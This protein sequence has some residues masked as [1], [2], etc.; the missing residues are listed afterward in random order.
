MTKMM[1]DDGWRLEGICGEYVEKGSLAGGKRTT[2]QPWKSGIKNKQSH[3][4]LV[5]RSFPAGLITPPPEWAR[6]SITSFAPFQIASTY[7][8]LSRRLSAD[9]LLSTWFAW[10]TSALNTLK[11]ANYTGTL[12]ALE[13]WPVIL[14]ARLPTPPRPAAVSSYIR[15]WAT[16]IRSCDIMRGS[17]E[18][19]QQIRH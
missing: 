2:S 13:L 7:H 4:I 9:M 6:P 11:A 15:M 1:D 14:V 12:P 5:G 19:T 3:V 18:A 10:N 17:Y 8:F 16:H